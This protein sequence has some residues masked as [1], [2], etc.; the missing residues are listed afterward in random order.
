M[1]SFL[2]ALV[3]IALVDGIDAEDFRIA[4]LNLA[5]LKHVLN[6]AQV[7]DGVLIQWRIEVAEFDVGKFIPNS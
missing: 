5:K 7:W 4:K 1:F 2:I 6:N 3:L